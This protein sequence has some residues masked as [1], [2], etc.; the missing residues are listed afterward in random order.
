MSSR[1]MRVWVVP[2]VVVLMVGAFVLLVPVR[3]QGNRTTTDRGHVPAA[4]NED[5]ATRAAMLGMTE[6][7]SAQAAAAQVGHV[8]LSARDVPGEKLSSTWVRESGEP[9]L[10][11]YESGL[12]ILTEVPQIGP[13]PEKYYEAVVTAAAR[14]S[15][16]ITEINGVPALAV[17][18]NTDELGTNPGLVRFE[19]GDLSIVV[20]GHGMSVTYLTEIA[21]QLAKV[22]TSS[23]EA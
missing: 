1:T 11:V 9:V 23:E 19:S 15:V 8:V 21:G 14:P 16:Y 13:D 6:V 10:E 2:V 17:E 22:N 5:P 3:W 4:L 18:P 20:S 12:T 7:S